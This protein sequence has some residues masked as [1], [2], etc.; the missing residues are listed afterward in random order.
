MKKSQREPEFL[1]GRLDTP[2]L[3]YSVYYFS[4]TERILYSLLLFIGGAA[5]GLAFYG[6]LFKEGGNPTSATRISNIVVMIL[7]GVVSVKVF[8]KSV[9]QH[10]KE[11]RARALSDQFRSLLD[12]INTSLSSGSTMNDAFI[13]APKSLLNQYGEQAYIIKELNEIIAG[14]HNG[15]TLEEMISDFAAR[16]DNE[17]IKNFANVVENCYRMGGDFKSVVRTT[18]DIITD[19]MTVSAEIA[20]KVSSNK[21]QHTAMCVIP[22]IL[23]TMLKTMSSMFA[24]NLA[25]PI[26]VI[27]TT[28]VVGIITASYFWGKKI[29]NIK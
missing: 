23:V 19:K 22:I 13:N 8:Y 14:L 5:V 11:K 20:T 17:D 7:A 16:S 27:A 26:G 24:E 15:L 12:S 10:L 21:L 3:N 18:K 9:N 29:I 25:T 2:M 1:T 4:A 28:I 6:G